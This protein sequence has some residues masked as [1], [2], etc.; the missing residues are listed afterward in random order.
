MAFSLPP[1]SDALTANM[2]IACADRP[3]AHRVRVVPLYRVLED[4][5]R[6]TDVNSPAV[7][8]TSQPP[9]SAGRASPGK[10][11]VV[12]GF[13]PPWRCCKMLYSC[14]WGA[15]LT[16]RLQATASN[17]R[18]PPLSRHLRLGEGAPTARPLLGRVDGQNRALLCE[19]FS[20]LVRSSSCSRAGLAN[21]RPL[22]AS[23]EPGLAPL[24]SVQNLSVPS[25]PLAAL[26]KLRKKNPL[27]TKMK[28]PVAILDSSSP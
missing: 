13:A 16:T 24:S 18:C 10:T 23:S 7:Q 2:G 20:F 22:V 8:P 17:C 14:T 19:P 5:V 4:E 6:K 11:P 26:E 12:Q 25:L 28:L 21:L 27:R 9:R 1:R 15:P 3:R